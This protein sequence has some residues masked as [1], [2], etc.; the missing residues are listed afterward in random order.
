MT[1]QLLDQAAV[2]LGGSARAAVA[3]AR[4]HV[5]LGQRSGGAVAVACYL[6]R[7]PA[8]LPKEHVVPGERDRGAGRP[9]KRDRRLIQRL[10]GR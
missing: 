1:A 9:T 3:L 8:P 5:L 7:S 6:D 4:D 2:T 10:K